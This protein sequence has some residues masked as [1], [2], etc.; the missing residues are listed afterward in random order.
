MIAEGF[1]ALVW[2]AATQ[3]Y[4]G[5]TAALAE[6]LAAGGPGRVVHEV[7]TSTMGVVGGALAILGVVV[8]PVT[9]GDTAFRVGRLILAEYFHVSQRPPLSRCLLALPLFALSIA[10]NFVDFTVIWRYFGWANQT[11][12]AVTLWTGAVW[13]AR[14]G[15]WW[16]LAALPAAFMTAVTTAYL[17]SA[18]VGFSLPVG[19]STVV[20][21]GLAAVAFA[22]LVVARPRLAALGDDDPVLGEGRPTPVEAADG[23]AC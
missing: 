12:A 13:L 9:S 14:R 4:Y 2:A 8:L 7:C 1:I 23:L 11:L 16:W 15:P 10:L 5:G 18:E 3:G 19:L 20:G 21:G 17:L 6:V 22:A